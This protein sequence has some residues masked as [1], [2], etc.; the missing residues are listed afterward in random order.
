[1]KKES[2]PR[3]RELHREIFASL[4]GGGGEG[5]THAARLCGELPD[6]SPSTYAL[7]QH[8]LMECAFRL[9]RARDL[10]SASPLYERLAAA[11]WADAAHRTNAQY[12]LAIVRLASG[13]AAGSLEACQAALAPD[14]DAQFRA[15]AR[16]FLL[17]LLKEERRWEEA[18]AELGLVLDDPPAGVSRFDLH[19]LLTTCL[20]RSEQLDKATAHVELPEPGG[21]VSEATAR[22]WMEAAFALEEGG[23][24]PAAAAWYDRLL[25][26]T[27]LPEDVLSNA[28][29]R[30]GL[31]C[32]LRMDWETGRRLYEAAVAESEHVPVIRWAARQRLARLLAMLEEYK[33][34]AGHFE[35]LCARTDAPDAERA[36]LRLEYAK[37]LWNMRQ[38]HAAQT[39]LL[40]CRELYPGSELEVKADLLLAEIFMQQGDRT[41]AAECCRRIAGHPS[42]EPLTKAAAL[43]YAVHVK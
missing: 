27:G 2:D 14:A 19:L 1:M 38:A 34:A 42:A 36:A 5:L 30:Y 35:V 21:S 15:P 29:F 31:V 16:F 32:E 9:E 39:E 13:D 26:Q 10:V 6:P 28:S 33:T 20:A 7:V 23:A 24:L 12:R 4:A 43:A 8:A 25:A 40:A 17:H 11:P 37:C 3:I 18:V 41:A 22:L